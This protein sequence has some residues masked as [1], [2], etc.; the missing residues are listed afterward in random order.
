M[1]DLDTQ[2][3]RGSII[4]ALH[5]ATALEVAKL[6]VANQQ[7]Y[8]LQIAGAMGSIPFPEK[9]PFCGQILLSTE[10]ELAGWSRVCGGGTSLPFK[11]EALAAAVLVHAL[12]YQEKPELLV[13]EL[14]RVLLPEG[15]LILCGF[16]PWSLCNLMRIPQKYAPQPGL[17]HL[18]SR[19]TLC[20]LLAAAGFAI[21]REQTIFFRIPINRPWALQQNGLLERIGPR[22]MPYFGGIYLI[23]ARKRV[24]AV[25]PLRKLWQQKPVR[26]I[27]IAVTSALEALD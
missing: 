16:N 12:E 14:E 13:A 21:E 4:E 20:R 19:H 2:L 26:R 3:T 5:G 25:T 27:G 24:H 15:Q 8:V 18:Q 23:S 9:L 17:R 10:P 22:W 1:P 11:T 7:E 6:L